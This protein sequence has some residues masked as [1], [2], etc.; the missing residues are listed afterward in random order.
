MKYPGFPESL[1]PSAL[2]VHLRPVH[3]PWKHLEAAA[4]GSRVYF[5]WAEVMWAPFPLSFLFFISFY[6]SLAILL[7]GPIV[8][9]LHKELWNLS[10]CVIQNHD[11]PIKHRKWTFQ[12]SLNSDAYCICFGV[13]S[14]PSLFPPFFGLVN[15]ASVFSLPNS[16]PWCLPTLF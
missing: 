10:N 9:Q 11:W 5:I 12:D 3:L 16:A 13:L 14:D 15:F 2:C 4:D 7:Q 8:A 6:S 1:I